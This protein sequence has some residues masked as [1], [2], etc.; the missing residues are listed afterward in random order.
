EQTSLKASRRHPCL[1]ARVVVTSGESPL[2]EFVVVRLREDDRGVIV[3]V[4]RRLRLSL[5]R[6]HPVRLPGV[7]SKRLPLVHQQPV[8]FGGSLVD[9]I[10]RLRA[11]GKAWNV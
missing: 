6:L 4:V 8:D 1:K 5:A 3:L 2:V 7:E 9:N 11:P 10:Y